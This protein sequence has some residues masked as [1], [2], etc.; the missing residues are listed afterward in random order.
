MPHRQN[1]RLA[2]SQDRTRQRALVVGDK[3]ERLFHFQERRWKRSPNSPPRPASIF[4]E[5]MP[6]QF[7]R[8]ISSRQVMMDPTLRPGE[9]LDGTADPRFREA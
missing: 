3:A 1:V 4:D 2:T 6:A 9:L 7:S 8:R 5:F